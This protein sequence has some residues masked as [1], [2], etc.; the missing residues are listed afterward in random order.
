MD[1]EQ[2]VAAAAA[3]AVEATGGGALMRGCVDELWSTFS[4]LL[5]AA[6]LQAHS[7]AATAKIARLLGG[8]G[9]GLKL[10]LKFGCG[11]RVRVRARAR[12]RVRVRVRIGARIQG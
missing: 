10:R 11:L 9:L 1:I 2:G 6:E 7:P 3:R 5:L 12:A 4:C 8:L